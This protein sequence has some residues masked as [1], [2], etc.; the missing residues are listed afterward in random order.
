MR[1]GSHS[2]EGPDLFTL[3]RESY[4]RVGCEGHTAVTKVQKGR[5][6]RLHKIDGS[7]LNLMLLV[8]EKLKCNYRSHSRH[9]PGS[10]VVKTPHSQYRGMGP[11]PGQGTKILHAT[12]C[13]Q[14]K[15]MAKPIECCK[16]K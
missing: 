13:D 8:T 15:C 14:K 1:W 3:Q 2:T 11:T 4:D 10:P 6:A 7:T 5:D 16:V 9:L 12:W